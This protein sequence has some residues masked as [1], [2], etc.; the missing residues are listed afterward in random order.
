TVIWMYS[1][2]DTATASLFLAWCLL[3][4]MIDN[5]LRPLLIGRGSD[6]P[7]AVI[8]L[9]VLGGL[10]AHGLI[11]LFVGPIV[12]ALGHQ[13]FRAWLGQTDEPAGRPPD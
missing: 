3:V 11:G 9:G 8:L 5:V 1:T 2:A 10:L 13:L 12:L 4:G 7:L 6:V